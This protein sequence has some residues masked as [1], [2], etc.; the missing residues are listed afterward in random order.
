MCNACLFVMY[1]VL[2]T[3]TWEVETEDDN[4]SLPVTFMCHVMCKTF[5]S[6]EWNIALCEPWVLPLY[7]QL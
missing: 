4:A 1:V 6:D 2:C 5:D 7:K 3:T